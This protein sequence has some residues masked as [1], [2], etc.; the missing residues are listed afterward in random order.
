MTETHRIAV[1][2]EA[3]AERDNARADLDAAKVG[4]KTW[5]T[6]AEDYEFWSNKVASLMVAV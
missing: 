6:A 3:T 4:S 1:L 5:R 2:A